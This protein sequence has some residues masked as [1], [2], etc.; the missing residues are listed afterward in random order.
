MR[1][2]L[3]WVLFLLVPL[4]G[5]Q[6]EIYDIKVSYNNLSES[7]IYPYRITINEEAGIPTSLIGC[8]NGVSAASIAMITTK[9]RPRY[10][11]VEWESLLHRK[12]YRARIGL[13]D[14]AGLWWHR[15]PFRDEK[16]RPYTT[17][18]LLVIQWRGGRKVAAML[19]AS[20]N[21]FSRGRLDLGE[22]EGVE[23][24]RPEWGPRLYLT[25]EDLQQ[26]P[27]GRYWAGTIYRYDRTQDGSLPPD[28]RFG[29]PRLPDGRVDV[30]KLP[31]EK[32]PILIGENGEHIPCKKY[33]CADKRELIKKIRADGWRTYPPD[34]APPPVVF[35]DAPNPRPAW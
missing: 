8:S 18:P 25:Y 19:V 35:L 2:R 20:S 26:K 29:C 34:K 4:G 13:D 5:V 3:L 14:K 1:L 17:R 30:T 11:V 12:V 9:T 28:K 16:G 21:D 31:P 7:Y 33:F 6:A 24:P 15:S 10:V 27:G 32:L 23:I 22:A